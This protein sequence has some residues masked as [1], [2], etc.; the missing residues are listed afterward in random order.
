MNL[1]KEKKIISF[2]F[3]YHSEKESGLW[4]EKYGLV[5]LIRNLWN[6][7]KGAIFFKLSREIKTHI[8][9]SRWKKHDRDWLI[10]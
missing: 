10:G 2:K 1:Q 8:C 6:A 3:H 5:D 7:N 9:L 4:Q